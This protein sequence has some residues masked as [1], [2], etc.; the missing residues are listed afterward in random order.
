MNIL[1]ALCL[2]VGLVVLCSYARLQGFS[3]VVALVV[4]LACGYGFLVFGRLMP[5]LI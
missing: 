3:R 4:V 2:V 5:A 1:A